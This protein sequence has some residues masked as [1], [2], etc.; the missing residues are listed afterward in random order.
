MDI[1]SDN[2]KIKNFQMKSLYNCKCVT[3]N[4]QVY[5]FPLIK[6]KYMCNH[7][8]KVGLLTHEFEI[9]KI[10]FMIKRLKHYKDFLFESTFFK[11]NESK[12]QIKK[13]KNKKKNKGIKNKFEP[14]IEYSNLNIKNEFFIIPKNKKWKNGFLMERKL[15]NSLSNY[16]FPN[17]IFN[18]NKN[19]IKLNNLRNQTYTKERKNSEILKIKYKYLGLPKIEDIGD[20]NEKQNINE[21]T[22]KINKEN[23]IYS[24]IQKNKGIISMNNQRSQKSTNKTRNFFLE[25]NSKNN[26]NFLTD[27]EKKIDNIR[28]NIINKDN[29]NNNI[30]FSKRPLI[31]KHNWVAKVLVKNLVYNHIFEKFAFSSINSR[32]NHN[33]TQFNYKNYLKT[34]EEIDKLKRKENNSINKNSLFK[35]EDKP[36]I[37]KKIN[38][39]KTESNLFF[40]KKDKYT[41]NISKINKIKSMKMEIKNE[42]KNEKEKNIFYNNNGIY[43]ALVY[44]NFNNFYNERVYKNFFV[45]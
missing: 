5:S 23:E 24:Y 33:S 13:M 39:N 12:N 27:N 9:K 37:K 11:E 35:S 43:D 17:N 36:L 4:C 18:R 20:N 28:N 42:N 3:C 14:N 15:S 7:E 34:S 1:E 40:N 22:T 26:K 19:N 21:K 41:S 16:K 8:D 45:E 32:N 10:Y 6:F 2:F 31:K 38:I 25:N 29:Y 44:D 30:I